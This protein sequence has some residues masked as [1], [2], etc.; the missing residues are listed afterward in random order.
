MLLP[1][2]QAANTSIKNR[3]IDATKTPV[4]TTGQTIAASNIV[5]YVRAMQNSAGSSN[6]ETLHR[7]VNERVEALEFKVREKSPVVRIPLKEM[8]TKSGIL[9]ATIIR[10]NRII[11][12]GGN[13]TIEIGDSVII[14]TMKKLM[15]LKDILDKH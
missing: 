10:G 2:A 9:V 5:R 11:I 4:F 14:V 13:D 8:K 15:D 6:V 1:P 12:P 3:N 7:L